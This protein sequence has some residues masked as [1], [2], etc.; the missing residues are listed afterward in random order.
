MWCIIIIDYY[1]VVEKTEEE[2]AATSP[3]SS[4]TWVGAALCCST[5]GKENGPQSSRRRR[6]TSPQ[7][8]LVHI[9]YRFGAMAVSP[10]SKMIQ[11]AKRFM[12]SSKDSI[13][14]KPIQYSV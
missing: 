10:N 9:H 4:G 2:V 5:R 3:L 6:S 13:D 14:M 11:N 7:A 1:A 8:F 12:S